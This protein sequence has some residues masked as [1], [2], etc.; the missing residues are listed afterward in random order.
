MSTP[1]LTLEQELR[2]A[3]AAAIDTIGENFFKLYRPALWK[4]LETLLKKTE[5]L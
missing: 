5:G 4:R 1:K 2:D 3:L